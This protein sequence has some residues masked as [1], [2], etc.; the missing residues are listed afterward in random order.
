MSGYCKTCQQ[1]YTKK[2]TK[3]ARKEPYIC[4]ECKSIQRKRWNDKYRRMYAQLRHTEKTQSRLKEKRDY[5]PVV[6]EDWHRHIDGWD[7]VK[8]RPE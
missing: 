3:S 5:L 7:S 8:A 6:V 4:G 2:A 1:H